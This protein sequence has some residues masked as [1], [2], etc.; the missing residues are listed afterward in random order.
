MEIPMN[1]VLV[2]VPSG[3]RIYKEKKN[4]VGFLFP[5]TAFFQIAL[6]GSIKCVF[7]NVNVYI[8]FQSE[9]L[10]QQMPKRL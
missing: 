8:T 6:Q 2:S 1:N 4:F 5:V 7:L 9:V 3:F 10:V